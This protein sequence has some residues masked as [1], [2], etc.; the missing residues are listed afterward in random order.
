MGRGRVS[1]LAAAFA[2]IVCGCFA[3][4]ADAFIYWTDGSGVARANLDGSGVSSFIT[5]ANSPIGVAVDGQY[6]YWAD[7]GNGTIGRANLDGSNPDQ[8]F[9]TT[10]ATDPSGVAVD[11]Q[12]IYWGNF[13]SNAIGRANLDGSSP[14][15]SFIT[16][17]PGPTAVAVDGQHVYWANFGSNAIGRAN[18]DGSSPDQSFITGLH[19]PSGVAVDGQHVYWPNS[20]DNSIGIANLDGTNPE[21]VIFNQARPFGVAVDS[22]HLYWGN[23]NDA[24]IGRDNINPIGFPSSS[25]ITG[26]GATGVAVDALP[27]AP[28]ALIAAPVTGATFAVGQVVDS[29]FACSEGKAGPG[30]STCLDQNGHGSGAAIDTTTPGPH[31]LT[32]TATSTDG[33]TGTMSSTYTVLAPPVVQPPAVAAPVLGNLKESHA[34]WRKGNAPAADLKPQQ[35]W[36]PANRDDV[37]VHAQRA[38]N[39]EAGVRQDEFG[40]TGDD[41][42]QTRVRRADQTQHEAP[43]VHSLSDRRERVAQRA[44][45]NRQDRISGPHQSDAQTQPRHL[46][47]HLHGH[48]RHSELQA[49][50]AEVH[51]RQIEKPPGGQPKRDAVA[52]G[53]RRRRRARA[54]IDPSTAIAGTTLRRVP[55]TPSSSADRSAIETRPTSAGR[56]GQPLRVR[57]PIHHRTGTGPIGG[58]GAGGSRR[59]RRRVRWFRDEAS[60]IR[61]EDDGSSRLAG[62]ILWH[63]R[64]RAI[65]PYP[66]SPEASF[67]SPTANRASGPP[68]PL[69]TICGTEL[70]P[71]DETPGFPGEERPALSGC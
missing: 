33:Q 23:L 69:R 59:L 25:F 64:R 43:Q 31:T 67:S 61:T 5:G 34:R 38:R 63:D 66:A 3:A 68:V 7:T 60:A 17:A 15:E 12:H 11:G 30:I 46:H 58:A 49:A 55:T 65:K 19:A 1:A 50:L 57:S 29:S 71:G 62:R 39:G 14:D 4:Q 52:G 54:A 53:L 18:L 27:L 16:G 22:Q 45:R 2:V 48:Q 56:P 10:G 9:I 21:T 42:E 41:Q 35:A 36:A 13:V 32:V 70:E 40:S 28:S 37:H 20:V 26:A 6:I 51:D 47:R 24:T 44:P 8:S